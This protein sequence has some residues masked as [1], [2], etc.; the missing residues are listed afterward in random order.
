[1]FLSIRVRDISAPIIA[2]YRKR[3]M[4]PLVPSHAPRAASNFT[5]PPPAPPSKNGSKKSKPPTIAP[6]SE[7]I[8][9]F[10]IPEFSTWNANPPAIPE[11]VSMFGIFL[12]FRSLIRA[13]T[14]IIAD[15]LKIAWFPT[16]IFLSIRF[17]L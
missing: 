3:F 5:S 9:P 11:K 12:V 16:G 6:L 10:S 1:M 8:A 17:L 15:P 2:L 13:A 4:M 14:A 7:N